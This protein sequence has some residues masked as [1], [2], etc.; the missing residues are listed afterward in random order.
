MPPDSSR[1]VAARRDRQRTRHGDALRAGR[2]A[3]GTAKRR[4]NEHRN[5][6]RAAPRGRPLS[7]PR[8]FLFAPRFSR[9]RTEMWIG[10][11][12]KLNSSRRRRSMKRR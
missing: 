5:T 1:T 4:L 7:V 10:V 2:T 6:E 8:Y 11:P 12:S 9:T 3:A